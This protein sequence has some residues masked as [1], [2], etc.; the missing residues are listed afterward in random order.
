[1]NPNTKR[2]LIIGLFSLAGVMIVISA[3]I[4]VFLMRTKRALSCLEFD[5]P[6]ETET[7]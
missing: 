6:S 1:M 5:K 3:S 7:A 4:A 2:G